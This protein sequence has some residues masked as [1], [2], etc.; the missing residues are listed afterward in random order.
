MAP[1]G[2]PSEALAVPASGEDLEAELGP[3]LDE[4]DRLDARAAQIE[5]GARGEAARIRERAEREAAAILEAARGDADAERVRAASSG[6]TDAERD[7]GRVRAGVRAEAAGIRARGSE[8]V[9]ELLAEVL[10]CVRQTG[11]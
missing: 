5:S 6:R 2:R 9:E 1:P 8:R 11:R 10:E 7:A 4:L 3:L